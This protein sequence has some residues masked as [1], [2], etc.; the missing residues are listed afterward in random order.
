MLLLCLVSNI[1]SNKLENQ[2]NL[3]TLASVIFLEMISVCNGEHVCL[4]H[5]EK[6]TVIIMLW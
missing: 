1:S 6:C 5:Y 2:D 4:F 3:S